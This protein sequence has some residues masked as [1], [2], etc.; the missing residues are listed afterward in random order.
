MS[1]PLSSNE[2][3]IS[4]IFQFSEEIQHLQIGENDF[5][6]SYDVTALFTNVPLEETIQILAKKAFNG[7]WFNNTHNLNICEGDLIELLTIATKDQLFQFNGNL[8]K[9]D[10]R[11]N[12]SVYRKK[13]N[14]G[15]L[16]HYQSHVDNRYKRS[17]IRTML[18]RANRLSSSPDLFSKRMPGSEN[19]VSETE[20]S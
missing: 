16:L 13:T 12:T 15:L 19:N 14:K 11:L 4:D 7:N 10:N 20:I 17:L 1:T 6:V 18:D 2:Y 8:Y 3:T 5:L 9:T